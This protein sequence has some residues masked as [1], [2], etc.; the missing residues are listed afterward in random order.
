MKDFNIR[1]FQDDDTDSVIAVWEKAGLIRSWNNPLLD[2]QRKTSFQKD[3]FFVGE[4]KGDIVATAMFGYEGHRG[5]LN[6]FAVLPQYQKQG[7]GRQMLAHG[8]KI[9]IE[10]GCPKLNLQIRTDNKEAI[11]FYQSAGYV[12]DAAISF[13]KRLIRD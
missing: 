1:T 4:F 8:E 13:G 9:L 6:Y 11:G 3:L 12:E 5:W 7:F 10:M 2:I